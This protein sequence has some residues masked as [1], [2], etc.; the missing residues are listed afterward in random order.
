MKQTFHKCFSAYIEAVNTSGLVLTQLKENLVIFI[1]F[2][3]KKSLLRTKK[4]I[5][6]PL[7]GVEELLNFFM[8]KNIYKK[9][10]KISI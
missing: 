7:N 9:N 6:L 3:L 2:F 5:G 1:S 10:L 4:E 8:V